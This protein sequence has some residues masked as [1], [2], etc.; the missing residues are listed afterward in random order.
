MAEFNISGKITRRIWILGRDGVM[1]LSIS[2]EVLSRKNKGP[3]SGY[4]TN[5]KIDQIA[6][7]PHCYS[8]IL[9]RLYQCIEIPKTSEWR[10]VKRKKK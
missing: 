5:K 2:I 10:Y 1:D 6:N 9:I 3:R 7:I 8:Q 4:V